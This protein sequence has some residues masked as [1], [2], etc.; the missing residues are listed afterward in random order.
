MK[1]AETLGLKTT[2]SENLKSHMNCIFS[3][4]DEKVNHAFGFSSLFVE[5]D[6]LLNLITRQKVDLF[7]LPKANTKQSGGDCLAEAVATLI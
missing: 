7:A 3:K 1:A 2:F 6:G 4:I 5:T